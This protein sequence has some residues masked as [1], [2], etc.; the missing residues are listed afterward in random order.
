MRNKIN[1]I[2]DKINVFIVIYLIVL[3][4]ITFLINYFSIFHFG[5]RFTFKIHQ[6]LT[7]ILPLEIIIYSYKL[8]SKQFRLNIFDLLI[9]LLI[10]VGFISVMNARDMTLALWGSTNRYEGFI[11]ICAYYFLFLNARFIKDKDQV[12]KI[13]NSLIVVGLLQFIYSCLQVFVRGDYIYVK[14]EVVSYRASGFIG[15][16]NMLGTYIVLTLLLA[17]GMYLLY[18]K[19]KKFYLISSLLLYI[20]LIL[21]QSTGP[22]FGFVIG[23]IFMIIYLI[24]KKKINIEQ[25][26]VIVSASVILLL[27]TTMISRAYCEN[28]FYDKFEDDFTIVGDIKTTFT[29][30]GKIITSSDE[31][32]NYGVTSVQQYGS[33]RLW[34]WKRS[35]KLVPKYLWTGAGIDNFG[36]VFMESLN[37]TDLSYMTNAY[38][39]RAHNEYLQILVTEGIFSLLFYLTLLFLVF[40]RGIKS[41]DTLVWVLMF[42]FVGYAV[43]AFSNIRVYNMAPFFFVVMG[44]LVGLTEKVEE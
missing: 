40:M 21:T 8:F 22:Y 11:Q 43:Q 15:H 41:K 30:L 10:L 4:P 31:E 36:I 28:K 44:I 34:I 5:S 25:I 39:D 33:N 1:A 3:V 12:I 16:P 29:T 14:N 23:L 42:G 32:D 35:L 24:I 18:D 26:L 27:G 38:I 9:F 7:M 19:N 20:N 2:L 17:L 6:A 13:I 37:E